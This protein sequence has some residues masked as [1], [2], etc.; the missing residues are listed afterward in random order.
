MYTMNRGK[1]LHGKTAQKYKFKYKCEQMYTLL[2]ISNYHVLL[3]K[4]NN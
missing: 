1:K 3:T 4:Y 2:L